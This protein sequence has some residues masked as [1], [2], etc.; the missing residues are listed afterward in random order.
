MGAVD[1]GSRSPSGRLAKGPRLYRGNGREC[2]GPVTRKPLGGRRLVRNPKREA[3]GTG[4]P[5]PCSLGLELGQLK[6]FG[7]GRAG[8]A[9]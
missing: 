2:L 4:V 3:Q 7:E 6:C 9:G 1:N 5:F 8:D